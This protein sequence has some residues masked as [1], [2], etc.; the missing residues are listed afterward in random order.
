SGYYLEG[1][2]AMNGTVNATGT[3]TPLQLNDI[4]FDIQQLPSGTPK[5]NPLPTFEGI[6]IQ[7][8]GSII[9]SF[10]DGSTQLVA[11]VALASFPDENGLHAVDGQAY[12]STAQSGSPKYGAVGDNGTGDVSVGYVESST[13]NLT[14][15]L[16]GL[17]VAQE[18][19]TANTKVVTVA[20]QLLQT[21]I[22]MIQG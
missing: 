19:Y 2:M 12:T 18:A 3:P 5:P 17:I 1:Y 7:S 10:S 21:T 4:K 13:T 14:S 15:S 11:K 9:A 8:D 6:S 22:A 20:S 16:T